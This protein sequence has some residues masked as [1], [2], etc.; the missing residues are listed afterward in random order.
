MSIEEIKKAYSRIS[1]VVNKTPVMSSRTLNSITNAKIHFKCE[2]FQKAGAFK[3]R[4]ACNAVFSLSDQEAQKGVATHS[5]GNHGAA[6]AMAAR[7]REIKAY[8]VMPETAP[9]VKQ[10]A[11]ANYG[12]ENHYRDG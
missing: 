3:A 4:G 12:A 10:A 8:V 9:K 5:S 6:L 2:N 1:Q 7:L 11:V